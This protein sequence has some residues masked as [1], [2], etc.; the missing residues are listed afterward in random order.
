MPAAL[1]RKKAGTSK[2][3]NAAPMVG[4]DDDTEV[5]ETKPGSKPDLL[6]A[7][8]DK[9]GPVAPAGAAASEEVAAKRRRMESDVKGQG[10]KQGNDDYN[11]FLAEMGD[12]LAAPREG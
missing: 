7:L 12:L 1:K 5:E 4:A 8:R 2:G 10:K 9:L 6:G 3:V 11:K